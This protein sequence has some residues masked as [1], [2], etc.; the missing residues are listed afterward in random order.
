[1]VN[2]AWWWTK[3]EIYFFKPNLF[4]CWYL[5]FRSWGEIR[6]EKSDLVSGRKVVMLTRLAFSLS[7]FEKQQTRCT[8]VFVIFMRGSHRARARHILLH[9]NARK[10]RCVNP[11]RVTS[12]SKIRRRI[13]GS[14]K[15][16]HE[17]LAAE[18]E[19]ATWKFLLS[20]RREARNVPAIRSTYY[21]L[22]LWSNYR[23]LF[24]Y[25]QERWNSVKF[26]RMKLLRVS[27][28]GFFIRRPR[29]PIGVSYF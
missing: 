29:Q 9:E 4:D 10:R 6:G 13:V 22:D 7:R 27:Y 23:L 14:C 2:F 28:V 20:Q 1:M 19:P 16:K 8:D 11:G 21:L 17:Q 25:F 5:R 24:D 26:I 12:S 18:Q 3:R 15:D